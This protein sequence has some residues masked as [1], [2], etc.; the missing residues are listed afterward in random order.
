MEQSIRRL[1][2]FVTKKKVAGCA[3]AVV[4]ILIWFLMPLG[5]DFAL[6]DLL[7]EQGYWETVPPAEYYLPGTI[8][9]IEVRSS[10]KIAIYPTC[11]IDP[12][13]LAKLTLHSQTVDRTLAERL[14]KGFD[15]S[16]RIKDFLPIGMEGHK[17]RRVNLTLQNSNI[18]QI[19]DEELMLVRKEVIKG[20][21]RE[22]I[23]NNINSGA[24]VCQ[25]RAALMG[26]LVYDLIYEEGGSAG[27]KGTGSTI[28]VETNQGN[29]DRVVGKG[30]IY[31]VNFAPHGILDPKPADCQVGSK[32]K[33]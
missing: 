16:D 17:A 24:T 12:E 29:S 6:V 4:G 19:T 10:G 11:K 32:N 13:L 14:N 9:T 33:A 31:G 22:A 1:A 7:G 8:N 18:L 28:K 23:E 5:K 15:V 20:S 30:L 2:S 27:M 26:D 25:T 21:C 3:L